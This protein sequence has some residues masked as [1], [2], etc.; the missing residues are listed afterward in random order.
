MPFWL[1]SLKG[2]ILSQKIQLINFNHIRDDG[3][4]GKNSPNIDFDPPF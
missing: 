3:R 1:K 4:K 2:I